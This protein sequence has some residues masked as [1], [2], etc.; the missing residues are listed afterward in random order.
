[1]KKGGIP[2][3]PLYPKPVAVHPRMADSKT[4][5]EHQEALLNLR[6]RSLRLA[7]TLQ[8]FT[9]IRKAQARVTDPDKRGGGKPWPALKFLERVDL[10]WL[11]IELARENWAG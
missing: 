3:E 9:D 4:L 1:M 11:A 6:S 7:Y 10:E 5:Q 2:N 8:N